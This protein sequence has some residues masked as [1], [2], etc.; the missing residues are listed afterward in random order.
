M[1]ATTLRHLDSRVKVV[2]GRRRDGPAELPSDVIEK[3]EMFLTS[4]GVSSVAHIAHPDKDAAAADRS[5][6][7]LTFSRARLAESERVRLGLL[8]HTERWP[9][10][11]PKDSRIF[12]N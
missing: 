12:D 5:C 2:L 1:Q 9:I 8:L 6:S 7:Q 11:L 4:L 3:R 10:A